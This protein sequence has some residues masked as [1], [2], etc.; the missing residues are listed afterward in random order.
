MSA[1]ALIILILSAIT[2]AGWNLIGK[3]KTPGIATFMVAALVGTF[4][5]APFPIVFSEVWLAWPAEIWLFLVATGA[6]QALYF[7]SLSGAYRHGDMSLVYPV[8]RSIP[9][10][11]VLIA[12]LTLG[13]AERIAPVVPI[14]VLAIVTG[15]MLLPLRHGQRIQRADYV[16]PALGF[17][18]LAAVGT[19]GYSII[20]DAALRIARDALTTT[21]SW[22]V[23]LV[24]GFGQG[25]MTTCWLLAFAI[26]SAK[27]RGAVASLLRSGR[28]KLAWPALMGVTVVLTYGLVLVSM[29][30]VREVSYVV[31]FRQ[32]SIPVGVVLSRVVLGEEVAPLKAIGTTLIFAGVV[33]VGLG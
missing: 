16:T 2:H 15:S 5:L 18:L 27:R 8:A 30:F 9:S 3:G 23:A 25:V 10:I 28:R 13:R 26:T 7:A 19:T 33:A 21:Q 31:A 17:A 20:D 32:L 22:K 11:L 6:F 29:A 14:G 4:V 24:Y 12:A 1:V